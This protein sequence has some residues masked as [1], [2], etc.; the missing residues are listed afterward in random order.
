[1]ILLVLITLVITVMLI[2]SVFVIETNDNDVIA[3]KL[4]GPHYLKKMASAVSV[5]ENGGGD[6]NLYALNTYRAQFSINDHPI[7]AE[8][9]MSAFDH[10][11]SQEFR[12]ELHE[13]GGDFKHAIL[14]Q[15]KPMENQFLMILGYFKDQIIG[16][17]L[18]DHMENTQNII[19]QLQVQLT[20]G[21]WVHLTIY[22]KTAFPVW[23]RSTFAPTG[24]FSFIIIIFAVLIVRHITRPLAELAHKADELGKGHSIKTIEPTGPEDIQNAIIAFNAMHKRIL[25]VNDHRAK[26]LAA[27][28]HDIR[29]PLTSMRLNAEYIGEKDVQQKIL[30]KISEMEQICEATV[31][32]AL[33]DSWAEKDKNFDL[34]SL[35][36][37]LCCDL[38]EQDLDVTFEAKGKLA[39][40][41]R[42]TALKRAI[43]NLI[44][45]GVEYGN[46]VDVYVK[47]T[48]EVVEI[49][50]QDEGSGIKAE[51]RERLFEPF[52]RTEESRNRNS[53]GIGLGMAIARS[54]I[55]S[56]GGEIEL[57]NRPEGG[58]DAVVIL[59]V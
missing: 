41:G 17:T 33:R 31:T 26:A 49:H 7:F 8:S 47:H 30:D 9:Q 15:L 23:I 12:H 16:N 6:N 25:N 56:H 43:N 35:I 28:S 21:R 45:N 5:M 46:R 32:F 13:L 34:I 52:E 42:P 59:P 19:L 38:N 55:R 58:L 54:V 4:N 10:K 36:E 2:F 24:L 22:D 53:G 20:D 51:D 50:I 3:K 27:I 18:E 1:M 44:R 37:S 48:K 14:R 29:T 40:L 11:R 57:N 39:F